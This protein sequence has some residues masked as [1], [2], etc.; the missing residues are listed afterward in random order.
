MCAPAWRASS[1]VR[2]AD[3]AEPVGPDEARALFA[4][5]DRP[6]G[7]WLV[8]V[9]GGPD[10]VALLCLLTMAV[11]GRSLV[12]ATVDHRLRPDSNDEALAV[13]ALAD[14]LGIAHHRLAWEGQKPA[15]GVPAAARAARYGLL[16]GLARQIGAVRLFTA[17]ALDDQ[18][19]TVMARLIAGSGPAGLGAMSRETRLSGLI[20]TRPL[21]DIAKARLVA[22]CAAAGLPAADDP[23]NRDVRF[24]RARLRQGLMPALAREGLTPVR[25]ARLAARLRRAEEALEA[26]ADAAGAGLPRPWPLPAFLALPAELRLRLLRRAIE[27]RATEGPVELGRLEALAARLERVAPSGRFAA[28][29]AGVKVSIY[30]DLIG[31]EAAPARGARRHADGFPSEP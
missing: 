7:P 22:T 14:R 18:A 27:A 8:A 11:S 9:S 16:T 25:L 28:T 20:L 30:R 26:A 21:L 3:R 4:D 5:L 23:T 13:A 24:L 10:S 19:E 6:D 29:L 2:A 12:A 15:S 1:S 17:H 31:I